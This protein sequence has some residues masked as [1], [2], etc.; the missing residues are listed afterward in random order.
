MAAATEAGYTE[1]QMAFEAADADRN[2]AA[3]KGSVSELSWSSF[4]W[5][6]SE[7]EHSMVLHRGADAERARLSDLMRG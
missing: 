6:M 1:Y 3:C 5:L 2:D 7:P 4:A